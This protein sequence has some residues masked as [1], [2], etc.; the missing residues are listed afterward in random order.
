MNILFFGS[1]NDSVLVLEKLLTLSRELITISAVVTQPAK[2]VGRDHVITPTP[3]EMF[4][5]QHNITTLTFESNPQKPWLYAN[6]Q[7][8][9]DTL[10]PIGAD[11]LISA[12]YGLKIPWVTIKA[13][14][15]G[16]INVHPSIL[17]HWRGADPVPW[18]ILS[19]DRQAGV[20]VVTLSEAFD[21]GI[22]LAQ[23]KI[24]IT[25]KDMSDPLRTKLFTMGADLLTTILPTFTQGKL[26]PIPAPHLTSHIGSV[27]LT[28]A[29]KFTR[30]D[31]YEPWEIIERARTTGEDAQRIERKFR[32]LHPW[33]GIWTK[34][35][36]QGSD[37][38]EEKRLKLLSLSLDHKL[39]AIREVQL[40]G[41][42]PVSW[43][44]F[45][46]AYLPPQAA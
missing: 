11:L 12:S 32:A 9:I 27:K 39:L 7:Q 34:L 43:K 16:G 4:A 33:P 26:R 37:P 40:E 41:K 22:I 38:T 14:R 28:Y 2:P 18:T 23:K 44:Q 6:E 8:V 24:P 10:E 13:A 17:P 5:K 15:Y 46:Q 21:Q 35:A 19:G 45:A 1:T 36:T 31:G 25:P 29:R 42:K 30:E 3:V 20:T